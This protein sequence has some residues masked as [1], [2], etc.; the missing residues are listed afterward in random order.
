MAKKN[1]IKKN[2]YYYNM[3]K[4]FIFSKDNF[5]LKYTLIILSQKIFL[6]KYKRTKRL[7]I[8]TDLM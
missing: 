3:W 2:I 4:N 6:I 7:I 8:L 5:K 1:I